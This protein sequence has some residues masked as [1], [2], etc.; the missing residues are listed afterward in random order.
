MD[1]QARRG[2]ET[3]GVSGRRAIGTYSFLDLFTGA[4]G[5]G[6]ALLEGTPNDDPPLLPSIL[7]AGLF[8]ARPGR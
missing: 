6:L 4:A 5:V 3:E 7:S 1:A 8:M 2:G